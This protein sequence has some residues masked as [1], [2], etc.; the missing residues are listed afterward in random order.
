[1]SNDQP[2]SKS[3][4]CRQQINI[5]IFSFHPKKHVGVRCALFPAF[6]SFFLFF[7]I[8]VK[9]RKCLFHPLSSKRARTTGAFSEF[10]EFAAAAVVVR[11][12]NF[13]HFHMGN[14]RMIWNF[15]FVIIYTALPRVCLR[16]AALREREREAERNRA[17]AVGEWR[18][19]SV[20]SAVLLLSSFLYFGGG[21][22][23]RL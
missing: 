1:M 19:L 18:I 2:S 12:L 9:R 16:H 17:T 6:M 8:Y 7:L 10:S 22:R 5:L 11:L 21:I 13:K 3:Q 20:S 14:L 4:R 15:N 23:D